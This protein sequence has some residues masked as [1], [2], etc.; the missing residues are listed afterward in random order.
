MRL[1]LSLDFSL[2][3][4]VSLSSLGVAVQRHQRF[5][6]RVFA[7]SVPPVSDCLGGGLGLATF[8]SIDC[9]FPS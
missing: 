5:G 7:G 6:N 2:H 8:T 4:K 1:Q 3:R 9:E